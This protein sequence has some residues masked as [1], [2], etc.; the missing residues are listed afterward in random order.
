MDAPWCVPTTVEAG[1]F[2]KKNGMMDAPWCVPTTIEA[3]KFEKKNGMMDAPLCV[4]TTIEAGKF[5]KKKR[6]DGRIMVRPYN[7]RGL[8]SLKRRTE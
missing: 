6:N 5:E 4:P 7:G 1:K 2:E 3:G 8:E